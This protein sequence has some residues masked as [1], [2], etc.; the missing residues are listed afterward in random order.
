VREF[1]LRLA[2]APLVFASFCLCC[3]QGRNVAAGAAI[4]AEFSASVKHRLAA[5]LHVYRR[6]A[7]VHRA[8]YEVTKRLMG[9]K[10]CPKNPPLL[11]FRFKVESVI[12]ARRA[13]S[14]G[15]VR[16]KRILGQER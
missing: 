3:P 1:Q 5:D 9:I 2:V 11:R 7:A 8:I 4:T 13:D 12:P 15:R 6:A 16:T 10:S 14:I